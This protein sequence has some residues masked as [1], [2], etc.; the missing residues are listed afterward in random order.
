MEKLK[1]ADF[2]QRAILVVVF[3]MAYFESATFVYLQ[4][5]LEMTPHTIFPLRKQDALGG[6]CL[7]ADDGE[8]CTDHLWSN[9]CE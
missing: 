6:T 3:A 2:R 4:R 9:C 7:D 1:S 8:S 5:A